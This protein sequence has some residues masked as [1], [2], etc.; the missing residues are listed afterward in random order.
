MSGGRAGFPL[1]EAHAHLFQTGRSLGMLD[2]SGC[3]DAGAYLN[4]FGDR[5]AAHPDGPAILAHGAR[6]EAWPRPDWPDLEAF[7]RATGDRPALAW[8]FDYH[9]LQANSAMLALAGVGEDTPD[10]PGG[11]LGR[12]SRGRLTGVVYEHAALHVW[13]A[14]PEPPPAERPGLLGAALDHLR[15]FAEIHDLKAQPWLGP[16]LRALAEEGR[17]TQRVVLFPLL[18]DLGAAIRTRGA[19]EHD[20][21]RLGGA[22]IF[23][24]GTLNSRTAWMLE[25]FA[26]GR[27]DHPRGTPMMTPGQIEDAVRRCDG[28]GLPLAAHAIGDGAVRA[29]LDA[30]ERVRPRTPGFRVEHA[31]VIDRADVPR[32]A[33]LGV[34]ASLQPCHLLTDVEALRTALPHRLERVLPVRELLDTGLEAGRTLLFG[35]D[36]PIV[37]PDPEDSVLAA[38]ARRRAGTPPEE[39]IAPDQAIDAARAWA[40]FRAGAS[41]GLGG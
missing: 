21:V 2:L 17:L 41:A 13:N 20:L 10:P 32:F 27:P 14:A 24:D 28:A 16:A 30:I 19:W 35:S 15:G 12:D 5:R 7:D 4:A 39:A 31:E 25:P 3:E 33:E 11:I 29:V 18:E 9:A 6:P 36:V 8:C 37:R 22:K 23:V 1:R 38:T 40:C 26:D 34:T